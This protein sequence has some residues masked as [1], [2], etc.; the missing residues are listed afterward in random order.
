MAS[1][2]LVAS[3]SA[4]IEKFGVVGKQLRS[5]QEDLRGITL[6]IEKWT[7]DGSSV[8][9]IEQKSSKQTLLLLERRGVKG[10][11][12]HRLEVYDVSRGFDV[13][14][15]GLHLFVLGAGHQQHP[16]EGSFP[17]GKAVLGQGREVSPTWPPFGSSSSLRS[18]G[19]YR[20]SSAQGLCS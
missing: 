7:E 3:G 19:R 14:G 4:T 6:R 18:A 13:K 17:A 12:A 9:C 5:Q 16:Q 11:S 1:K 20:T 10:L 8:L 15:V 2:S